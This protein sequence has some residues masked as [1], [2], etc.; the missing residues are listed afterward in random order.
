M[1]SFLI[2]NHWLLLVALAASLVCQIFILLNSFQK[3]GEEDF[4]MSQQQPEAQEQPQTSPALQKA[5]NFEKKFYPQTDTVQDD[6]QKIE[7]DN[8]FLK[9]NK[10]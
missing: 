4:F 10:E 5:E 8:F 7:K 1:F 6:L 9:S 3:T 2:Q